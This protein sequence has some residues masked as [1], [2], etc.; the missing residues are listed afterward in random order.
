MILVKQKK[1]LVFKLKNPGRILNIIPTAKLLRF[2]GHDLVVVPHKVEETTVLRN[3][4]FKVPAP[5]AY[6]YNWPGK[7][8]PFDAQKKTV[9]FLT[10][11]KR[12]FCNNDIGT[13]KTI[14][15]LWAYDFLRREGLHKRCLVVTPLS[16]LERTWADEIFQNFPHL[17]AAVLHGTRQKRHKLLSDRSYDIYLVNH[18]GVEIIEDALKDRDD[19]TLVII[20]E[21]AQVA[22]NAKTD[23]WKALNKVVNKHCIIRDVWGATGTPIPNNP[24]DA[25]AQVRLINPSK[26]PPY[27]SKFRD[28]VMRQVSNF[29]WI[30]RSNALDV[31]YEV[32]Q[33]AIRFRRDDCIDLP[34]CLYETRAVEMTPA[35]QKA[36][37]DM[38]AKMQ[39]EGESGAITAVNEAAKA[40]KLIQIACGVAYNDFGDEQVFDPGHRLNEVREIIDSCSTKV[41]V[42]VPFVSVVKLVSAN[43]AKYGIDCEVVYGDVPKRER[44]RIFGEFQTKFGAKVLV[45]QPAA[46]SHGLTLT[47]ASTII[48]YAP[49]TSN[50]I[51]EQANGRITRPGQRNNQLIIMLEGS[52]I[53]R[54]YYKRLQ[55]KQKVQ[56]TLLEMIRAA[57]TV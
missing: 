16:T 32:M 47:E 5:V 15:L 49:V 8:V 6:Q 46:M 24:T 30:P 37:K 25:W 50:D 35:Q 33:P 13:G 52:E 41:I 48:W 22:R 9:E 31:V 40:T 1:A 11:N 42:F 10:Q 26:V 3:L 45:A 34:P 29:T 17:S 2:K 21:L 7:Y 38:L 54:R 36:Y 27:F 55:N 56:G 4:G 43:L 12:A 57:E 53:E 18:D 20:D 28:Q 14:S 44:D 51:F 39:A 23:R 19:I